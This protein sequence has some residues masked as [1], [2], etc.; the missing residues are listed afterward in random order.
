MIRQSEI[1]IIAISALCIGVLVY[2]FDRNAESIYLL[3]NWL[4]FNSTTGSFFGT[5]GNYIPTFV[6]VYAFIL[7]T[8]AVAVPSI[9]SIIPVCL[10][11]FSLDSLLEVAQISSIARWIA[12]HTPDWFSGIPL[13]ENT[14]SYFMLGT[15]DALDLVSIAAGTLA[16]Y[17]TVAIT[18]RQT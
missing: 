11:W 1:S 18:T 17:L 13:L 8:A 16:A 2:V 12:M 4:S 15:F 9:T 14:A 5:I 7:L 10:S 6:H 3:P